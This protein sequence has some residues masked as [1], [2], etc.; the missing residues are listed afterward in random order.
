MLVPLSVSVGADADEAGVEVGAVDG[1]DTVGDGLG[2]G[3]GDGRGGL[4]DGDG[5]AGVV[6]DALGDGDGDAGGCSVVGTPL[7][8]LG[9]VGGVVA[10]GG[11]VVGSRVVGDA[12]PS[13]PGTASLDE[14]AVSAPVTKPATPAAI[15]NAA[16]RRLNAPETMN[17]RSPFRPGPPRPILTAAPA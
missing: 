7:G 8:E 2:V 16:A 3:V 15:S 12:G 6:G 5:L 1:S 17:S 4:V 13:G 11:D 14:G 9:V 10:E